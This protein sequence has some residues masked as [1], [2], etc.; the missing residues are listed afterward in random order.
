MAAKSKPDPD[1]IWNEGEAMHDI[2][3][4]LELS[5]VPRVSSEA[6]ECSWVMKAPLS[7]RGK[8]PSPCPLL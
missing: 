1:W 7:T 3:P 2:I 4:R 6:L 5:V 8:I